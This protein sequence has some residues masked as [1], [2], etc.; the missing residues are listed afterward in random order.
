MLTKTLIDGL[1]RYQIGAKLRTLRLR[2]KVG[3]VQLGQHTGLSPALLSKVERGR[4]FPTLP[5]LLRIALVFGVGLEHF[6]APD[7]EPQPVI[8]RQKDR[9]KFPSHPE[10]K[11]PAYHFESLDFPATDRPMNAYLVQFDGPADE[12]AAALAHRHPGVELIYLMSG[13]LSVTV[14]DTTHTL[15]AGDAM[16]M[17]GDRPHSYR[18]VGRTPCT[19][20][21]VTVPPAGSVRP[22]VASRT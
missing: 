11:S 14:D 19:G 2:K 12:R 20:V 17:P 3:L 16:Y 9:L 8:V 6:F 13:R 21:V 5:T 15:D 18:R 22:P 10:T 7:D 4:L 1:E